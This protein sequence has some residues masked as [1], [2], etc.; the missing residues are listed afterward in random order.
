MKQNKMAVFISVCLIAAG[1]MSG[2]M[3]G[4]RTRTGAAGFH[5]SQN[6]D[7]SFI[8]KVA[9]LPFDN[10]TGEKQAG[11]AVRQM[12]INELL[13]SGLVD[14]ALP[15]DIMTALDK[16]KVASQ[17][18]P[19]ADQLKKIGNDLKV[20]AMIF[21]TVNKFGEVRSGQFQA[22]EV[23]IT[24]MMADANTGVIIWSVTRSKVGDSFLSRHF[25]ARS[26][27]LSETLQKTVRESVNTL[28]R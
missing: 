26:D 21:G 19:T 27:T 15:G 13:V 16:A 17:T 4:C 5:V 2:L 9:V 8:K 12:V 18:T 28:G 7:F 10:L 25:G 1:L 24:L 23:S 3:S 22:P 11:E 20:Q 6:F 14:V